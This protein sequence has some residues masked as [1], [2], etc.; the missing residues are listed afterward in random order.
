MAHKPFLVLADYLTRQ[1]IGVLR[2]DD[3]GV[4]QST[5]NFGTATTLDFAGDVEAAVNFLKNDRKIR[6]RYT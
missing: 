2:F 5:G 3:R 4:G 6:N 1:G